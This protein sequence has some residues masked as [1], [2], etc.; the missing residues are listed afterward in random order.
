MKTFPRFS[1]AVILHE[2]TQ[3]QAKLV[4]VALNALAQQLDTEASTEYLK[5]LLVHCQDS[6][7]FKF[8]SDYIH[9]PKNLEPQL[10]QLIDTVC[11]AYCHA[12]DS[13]IQLAT[14]ELTEHYQ[15]HFDEDVF[16]LSQGQTLQVSSHDYA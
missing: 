11:A 12:R 7:A 1:D 3:P 15:E 10:H 14:Q 5:S 8:T 2:L 13:Q 4:L 9:N 6:Y 16:S